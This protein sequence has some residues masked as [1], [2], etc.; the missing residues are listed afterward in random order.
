MAPFSLWFQDQ[1]IVEESDHVRLERKEVR[2][3]LARLGSARPGSFHWLKL[4]GVLWS[5]AVCSALCY[6]A[7][8]R[9]DYSRCH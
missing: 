1:A 8:L 2:L 5:G 4:T 6:S 9:A 3:L 7:A